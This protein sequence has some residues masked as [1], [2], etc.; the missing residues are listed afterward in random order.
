MSAQQVDAAERLAQLLISGTAAQLQAAALA[1]GMEGQF[2]ELIRM[3]EQ[4]ERGTHAS[5]SRAPL[6]PAGNVEAPA[7]ATPKK[8]A[9]EEH[10][11]EDAPGAPRCQ[12]YAYAAEE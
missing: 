3:K 6:E 11:S 10:P 7:L 9:R 2:A 12:R 4:Q 8:R 1:M 5:T